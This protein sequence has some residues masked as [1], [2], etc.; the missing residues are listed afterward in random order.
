MN[1]ITISFKQIFL[2]I[3]RTRF[4]A[5]GFVACW[6]VNP[7]EDWALCRV[8]FGTLLVHPT[9]PWN[10]LRPTQTDVLFA[11]VVKLRRE[12]RAGSESDTD[13]AKQGKTKNKTNLNVVNA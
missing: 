1:I 8:D 5:N 9:R 3:T 7:I 6:F 10:C 4:V 11:N 2:N 13:K 12:E